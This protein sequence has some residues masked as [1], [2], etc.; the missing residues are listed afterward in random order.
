[1]GRWMLAQL[2]TTKISIKQAVICS[3]KLDFL[4]KVIFRRYKLFL[5]FDEH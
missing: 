3:K 2:K 1:M 4:F 5:V